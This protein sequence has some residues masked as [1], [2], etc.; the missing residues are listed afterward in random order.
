MYF[1]L[2]ESGDKTFFFTH[3]HLD[4]ALLLITYGW[5]GKYL[6]SHGGVRPKIF[7]YGTYMYFLLIYLLFFFN[8]N[9]V[10]LNSVSS[11]LEFAQ[12]SH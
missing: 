6:P 1:C 2:E 8:Q 12:C 11:C 10:E 3:T 5:Q 9:N 7:S 4:Y